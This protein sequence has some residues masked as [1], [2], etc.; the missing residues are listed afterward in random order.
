MHDL[1]D[2]PPMTDKRWGTFDYNYITRHS[3]VSL[4]NNNNNVSG[5]SSIHFWYWSVH[6]DQPN[7][8]L[9]YITYYI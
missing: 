6:P 2:R 7:T 8:C 5:L 4:L 1:K 9:L 3:E